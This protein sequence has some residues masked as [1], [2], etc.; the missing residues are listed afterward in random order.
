MTKFLKQFK[1]INSEP[2]EKANIF[3]TWIGS[4]FGMLAVGYFH[5]DMLKGTDLS[6]I[7]GSFGASAVLIYGA[8]N[9]PLAQPRNLIGGHL[10]SAFIG[11]SIYKILPDYII[12]SS[13]LAVSISIIAMEFT[14]T[15]H[16]PGGATAL[17]AVI[18]GE[19][20]HDLGYMY[21]LAPVA[22]GCFILFIIA[23]IVNNIP[24]HRHYPQSFI[25]FNKKWFSDD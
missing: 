19:S 8:I 16:P 22:T 15:L 9:S 11:V 7:I 10:L 12:L 4:F 3:W 21:M 20:I 18:G 14:L 6:L 13:A 25:K 1:K 5:L 24:K 23:I 17:I 2:L